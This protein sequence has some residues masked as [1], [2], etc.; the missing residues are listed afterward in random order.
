MG[1]TEKRAPSGSMPAPITCI[2]W[3]TDLGSRH[4]TLFCELEGEKE[5]CRVALA[6]PQL[7]PEFHRSMREAR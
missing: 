2:N 3:R 6:A 7:D 1:R 5:F 4:T